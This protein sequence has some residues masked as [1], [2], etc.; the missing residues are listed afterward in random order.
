MPL[1]KRLAIPLVRQALHWKLHHRQLGF[2][3]ASTAETLASEPLDW[4][5]RNKVKK[6]A[7]TEQHNQA[8]KVHSLEQSQQ[9]I[10]QELAKTQVQSSSNEEYWRRKLAASPLAAETRKNLIPRYQ[11]ISPKKPRTLWNAY[12]YHLTTI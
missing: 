8:Q 3:N 1:V 6:I 10:Q 9:Q 5:Q 11:R 7:K 12:S 4:R 2:S